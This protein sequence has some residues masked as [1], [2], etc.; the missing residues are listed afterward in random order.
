MGLNT[1]ALKE[2]FDR[3]SS[4]RGDRIVL[5]DGENYLRILPP[6]L[7]YLKEQ[8][9]Y[10]SFE[11]FIHYGLGIEGNKSHEICP[12]TGGK[13]VRCPVCEAVWKLYKT[14]EPADKQLAGEIRAKTRHICNVI[15][16]NN[17]DKGVQILESGTQ[18]YDELVKFITNPKYG[19]MLDLDKG[20]NITITK[21]NAK[22]SGTGYPKYDVVP[23]PDITSIK[24]KLP[25][26]WKEQVVKLKTAFDVPKSYDALKKILEGE[27][28]TTEVETVEE[29]EEVDVTDNTEEEVDQIVAEGPKP[30]AKSIGKP[31][32]KPVAKTEKPSCFGTDF[33]PKREECVACA[34]KVDCR[35]EYLKID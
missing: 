24:D 2:R 30:V 9:D 16:L 13:Q 11:Y 32:V 34:V 19:D 31:A 15:D 18:I 28:A 27:D 6:S 4:G 3:K 33:G 14:K 1:K 26:N 17:L 10:I 5:Q 23:D 12:K 8:V 35:E 7:D 22:E 20:R 29:S 21:M 25:K